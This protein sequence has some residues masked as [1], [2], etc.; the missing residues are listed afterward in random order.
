MRAV[1]WTGKGTLEIVDRPI[2]EPRPGWVRVKISQVGI[3]GSDLHF[4]DGG[5]PSPV[6]LV[7]GHELGATIDAYGDS[8]DDDLLPVGTPVAVEPIVGCGRCGLCLVGEYNRC[9]ERKIFGMNTRGGMA[10]FMTIPN[11]RV[12]ALPAG[13]AAGDG[14][15]VEP[16]AVCV[17]GVRFGGI[18]LGSRVAVLGTGSIGLVSILAARAAG[19]SEVAFTARHPAQRELAIAFGATAL[20]DGAT[21]DYDVVIE[22]VG[23]RADTLN[24]AVGLARPGGTISVLG[25]F[26]GSVDIDG[27]AMGT[28]E[29]RIVNANC[30]GRAHGGGSDFD[31][32]MSLFRAHGDALRSL[33]THRFSLDRANEALAT[34]ADKA[35]GSIK[36]IVEP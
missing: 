17:R 6:G 18:G 19:A 5:F 26:S 32:A 35:T 1:V 9:L 15:L 22:T 28:K 21:N 36:V 14:A 10:E 13:I 34:A 23:G 27:F 29:L 3:C 2:P 4:L 25:V 7:P 8:A 31:V 33:V 11:D 16:M 24:Q 30:Y 20:A 12:Y